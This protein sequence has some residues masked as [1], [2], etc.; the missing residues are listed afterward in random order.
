MR[1]IRKDFF[2]LKT[3]HLFAVLTVSGQKGERINMLE[4]GISKPLIFFHE[5]PK[6][7]FD[8]AYFQQENSL[9]LGGAELETERTL[10]L[11][12]DR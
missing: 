4:H 10:Y 2:P 11:I 12:T 9:E 8:C 6:T 7:S 5:F 3:G 1:L